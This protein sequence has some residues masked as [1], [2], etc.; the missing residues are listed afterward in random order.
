MELDLAIDPGWVLGLLLAQLRVAVFVITSPQLGRA[1]GRSARW[2][3]AVAVGFALATPV[4]VTTTGALLGHALVNVLVGGLMGWGL[5]LLFHTFAVAGGIA[6][7][8]AT[9]SIAA[10]L[11]PTLGEQGAVFSRL[12][13]MTGLTLFNVGGG[14]T[15][16]VTLLGSS[17]AAIPLD[18]RIR[19]SPGLVD[20]VLEDIGTLMVLG[21]EL[22]APIAAALFLV[23]VVLGRAARFA[24]TAN[25]FILGMPVKVGLAMLLAVTCFAMFPGFVDAIGLATR[26]TA[27]ELLNGLGVVD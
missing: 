27:I 25:V 2:A 4:A 8:S 15:L 21:L 11:D 16:L 10:V 1:A 6:D 24:P 17:V 12:F 20:V 14:L 9:T 5:G 3:F 19:P 13:T 7:I 22:A 26:D 18:G 23:E